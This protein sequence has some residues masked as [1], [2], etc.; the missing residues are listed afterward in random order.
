MNEARLQVFLARAL[1]D[2]GAAQSTMLAAIGDR[3]G[4]YRAM[5][6]GIPASASDIAGRTGTAEP[7]VR[8]WLANQACSGYVE[9]DSATGRYRLPEEHAA[10]LADEG[11]RA[12]MA[13]AIQ[14]AGG[15]AA[16]NERLA[17]A[18]RDGEGLDRAT[19][20]A[21]IARGMARTSAARCDAGTLRGWMGALPGVL[22][23]L[24]AGGAGAELGCGEGR[25][26][27]ALAG[28]CP[29]ARWTGFDLDPGAVE[30][31]RRAVGA[32]P[33]SFEVAGGRDFP[34]S[35]YDLV[36]CIE[37]FH[38]M[39]E[40]VAVARRVRASLREGGA[41]LIVEPWAEDRLED[42][43]GPWGRLVSSMAA[44]H[45]LPV[46]LAQGKGAL[47]PLA[48][49][50]ALRRVLEEAGFRRVD[51]LPSHSYQLVLAAAP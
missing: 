49:E 22:A 50:A 47:G 34:G 17:S 4:L 9:Y 38:E 35:G 15:L 5:A 11:G 28:L 39:A 27:A 1:H 36:A 26:L 3:L 18:F 48:G 41:W 13:G 40:P 45:C 19:L 25:T 21:E 44:L 7:Y 29:R 30:A 12:F 37:S 23:R 14:V 8:A 46:S 20:P 43:I 51:R 42:N 2:V 10:A 24:E 32:A 16:M 31:A 33:V 6:D